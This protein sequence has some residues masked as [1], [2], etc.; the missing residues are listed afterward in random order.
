MKNGL[1]S[2][3]ILISMLI[4]ILLFTIS[5]LYI[6]YKTGYEPSSLIV[7][8]FGFCATEGGLL[9]WIKT[10]KTKNNNSNFQE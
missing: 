6:T 7:A 9:A 2:K 10:I 8:V 3:I 4:F 1:F 5:C